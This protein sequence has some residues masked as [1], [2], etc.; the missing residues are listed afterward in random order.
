MIE[1]LGLFHG[2]CQDLWYGNYRE[3]QLTTEMFAFSRG[4]L[5]ITVNNADHPV[6]FDLRVNGTFCGALTG[7][8][9]TSENEIL[10][11]E[12]SADAGEIWIPDSGNRPKYKPVQ[13]RNRLKSEAEKN[14]SHLKSDPARRPEQRKRADPSKSY[15]EMS[16]EEL[17]AEILAKM[18]ANGP[19][20]DRMKQ[21][22][23]EN[24]YRDSLLNWVRSF[25]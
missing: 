13:I 19:V 7:A 2:G 4:D 9:I 6:S 11:L 8:R 21:D 14:S 17:Q 16:I 5:I 3:L 20:T 12:L 23:A 15:E 25:R 22:V 1:K 18:A 24:I 10:H